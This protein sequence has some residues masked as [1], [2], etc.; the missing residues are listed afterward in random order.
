MAQKVP[1][2]W[3]DLIPDCCCDYIKS[4][5]LF[6]LDCLLIRFLFSCCKKNEEQLNRMDEVKIVKEKRAGKIFCMREN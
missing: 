4:I 6:F 5:S 1:H 3:T 2:L